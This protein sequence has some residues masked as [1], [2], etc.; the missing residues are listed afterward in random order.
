MVFERIIYW[1]STPWRKYKQRQELKNRIK[2]IQKRDP[3][4]YK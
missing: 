3:F 1:L 4:I 2:E